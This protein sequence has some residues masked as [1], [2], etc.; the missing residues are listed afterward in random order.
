MFQKDL[1]GE[2][3]FAARKASGENQEKLGKLLGV[4]KTQISEM[5]NGKKTTTAEK[6]ALICR[7]YNISSDYLLGLTDDPTPYHRKEEED[8]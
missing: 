2:R 8:G 4:T 6:I 1:F 5:E 7:H 3:L